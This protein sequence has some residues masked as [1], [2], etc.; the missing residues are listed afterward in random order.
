LAR[1]DLLKGVFAPIN[2]GREDTLRTME[3]LSAGT[4]LVA[5][6]EYLARPANTQPGSFGDWEI[7][8]ERYKM[9]PA[10]RRNILDF[11][12]RPL[13]TR[14]LHAGRILAATALLLPTDNRLRAIANGYLAASSAALYPRH[15][16][17]T[18]GS[19]QVS[20]QTSAVAFVA[21]TTT[22]ERIR[23]AAIWYVALQDALAYAVSGWVKLFGPSWRT[24]TAVPGV[25]RT[26]TYGNKHI[27]RIFKDRPRLAQI[28][29]H[30]MLAFEGLFPL[31]FLARGRLTRPFIA[32]AV[33]FH[34]FIA[35]SMGL[36]R[37]L[38]AFGSMLPAVAYVTNRRPKSK[39]VPIAAGAAIGTALLAGA[40]DAIARNARIRKLR[41]QR[42][43][44]TTTAGNQ[45]YYDR[46]RG[47]S[48]VPVLILD[49]G[50]LSTPQHFSWLT[51]NLPTIDALTYWRA[52]YGPSVS[53]T[54]EYS[55]EEAAN[56]LSDLIDQ[57]PEDIGPTFLC[58]HSL[59]G[60]ISRRAAEL[61]KRPIAGVI[62]L[63]SSHPGQLVIS[64]HQRRGAAG[65]DHALTG[66]PTS[67]VLGW[68]WLLRRPQWLKDLPERVQQV[69]LDQYRNARMWAA[70]AK[71]WKAADRMFRRPRNSQL[72]TI[73][74]PAL[75]ITAENTLRADE[76][77]DRLHQDLADSHPGQ[78]H[79]VVIRDADHDSILTNRDHATTTAAAIGAFMREV[80]NA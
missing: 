29:G 37:F 7:V 61:T 4:H 13:V 12:S 56:D 8:R 76:T 72:D 54:G 51:E 2:I 16:L 23:D 31:V 52:G 3:R 44:L 74:V 45:L 5:S 22:N 71:E 14:T 30:G 27:W 75:V 19:D 32:A 41:T 70:G 49:H 73:D 17:G 65:F 57:L 15:N 69:T 36:G 55:V 10:W 66:V 9:L 47:L 40:V 67:L 60:L 25:M 34:S 64:E 78:A 42:G 79:R 21:R 6:A 39:A 11:V 24:G 46:T 53:A 59:G 80:V 28:A 48:G 50:M 33:G 77:Q 68:G 62:Y 20:F 38:T 26:V 1:A 35:G 43:S 18:D 63:D 58:G